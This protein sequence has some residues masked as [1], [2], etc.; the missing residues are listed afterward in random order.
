[1]IRVALQR[2]ECETPVAKILHKDELDAML[3]P[4]RQ[5]QRVRARAARVLRQARTRSADIT[6]RAEARFEQTLAE[7]TLE[8][9]RRAER[10]RHEAVRDAAQW[11]ID[12]ARLEDEVV[13]RIEHD[14]RELV[15]SSIGQLVTD[16]VRMA[17]LTEQLLAELRHVADHGGR[18]VRVHP[19]HLAAVEEAIGD[20]GSMQCVSDET[21]NESQAVLE[22]RFIR[23]TV[24]IGRQLDSILAMLRKGR[25]WTF[26]A[27]GEPL[28]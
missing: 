13:S 4:W 24:D 7:A 18:V 27:Y 28:P 12:E 25:P 15:I 8:I 20:P 22:T 2:L 9:E 26:D 5:M 14:V 6:A 10:A 1:M 11:L 3:A 23:V 17:L 19:T 21:L 16:K